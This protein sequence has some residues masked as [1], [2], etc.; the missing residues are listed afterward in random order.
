MGETVIEDA[1]PSKKVIH[2]SIPRDE[3]NNLYDN[4]A[5]L[6]R[7]SLNLPGFRTG[8]VPM[9]V[10]EKK[11]SKDI[12]KSCID[13]IV[14]DNFQKAMEKDK[15]SPVAP[16]TVSNFK[17]EKETDFQFDINVDIKPEIT[18]TTYK[19]LK[20]NR[21]PNAVSDDEVNAA[22]DNLKHQ[23]KKLIDIDEKAAKGNVV[24]VDY[25][26]TD[27][28]GKK[29]KGV[30]GKALSVEIGGGKMI[31]GFENE[32]IGLK[33]GDKKKFDIRFPENYT[34]Q[35]AGKLVTFNVVVTRIAKQ[36]DPELNDE[37]AGIINP[38][39]KNLSD[40]KKSIKEDIGKQKEK[41]NSSVYKE[42]LFKK[43]IDDNPFDIPESMLVSESNNMINIHVRDL[44]Y[45]GVKI[46]G[47]E[48]YKYENLRKKFDPIA[49]N[50]V[51]STLIVLYIADKE[52]LKV[53]DDEI[54]EFVTLEAYY[55]GQDPKKAYNDAKANDSLKTISV[56]K[57]EEKVADLLLNNMEYIDEK[58]T[59]PDD[60]EENIVNDE[61]KV[62]SK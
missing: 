30:L 1:K 9:H 48:S 50:R 21:L 20:L 10:I 61:R 47:N 36:V 18:I 25:A 43:V 59:K 37:F 35:L 23:N 17:N 40:L 54:K 26:G 42:K 4:E 56:L 45:K 39:Y 6:T 46:E 16:P 11:F 57:L 27:Q 7:K 51:K 13:K 22:V 60:N 12:Q 24:F 3:F 31:P 44:V 38:K 8:K 62:D 29:I 19:G 15:F 5:K 33:K 52:N 14:S 58:E 41:D 53:S 34:K 32:L 49:E 2:V 55:N 28:N